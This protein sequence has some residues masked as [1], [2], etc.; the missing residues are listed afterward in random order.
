MKKEIQVGAQFEV[1]NTRGKWRMVSERSKKYGALV[2][3]SRISR[4]RKTKA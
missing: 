1:I 3:L 4:N 2:N